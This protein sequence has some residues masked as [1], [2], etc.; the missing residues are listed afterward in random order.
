[1]EWRFISPWALVVARPPYQAN[2]NIHD[3]LLID[4]TP[5]MHGGL[6]GGVAGCKGHCVALGG[7][8]KSRSASLM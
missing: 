1:M 5:W 8:G 7:C 3:V 4:F 6:H 2:D